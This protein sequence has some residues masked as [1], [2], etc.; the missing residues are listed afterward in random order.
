MWWVRALLGIALAWVTVVAGYIDSGGLSG[1][2]DG[3]C[4]SGHDLPDN[5]SS[6]EYYSTLWPPESRCEARLSTGETLT[7]TYPARSTWR[8]AGLVFLAAMVLPVP[9]IRLWR[10]R[11]RSLK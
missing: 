4:L 1:G 7:R 5:V 11:A 8:V 3:P 10:R 6:A 2:L 9:F